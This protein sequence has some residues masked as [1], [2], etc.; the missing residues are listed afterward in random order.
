M[1][2]FTAGTTFVDGVANDVTAAKLGALITNATPTS[3]LI[4]DRTAETVVATNDTFLIGDASD[5]NTL[6]RMTVANVMKAEHTG[7]INTTAGTI[8]ELTCSSAR[9]TSGTVAFLNS[10]TATIPTLT[11]ITKITSG[12]G[13]AAAPAISPT[14]DANTGIFFPVADTIAF[15]EGGTEAMRIDASG[16]V[17]IGSSSPARLLTV[18][19]ATNPE[20]ALYT[21]GAERVKLSTGGSAAS[22]L[23]IDI[24]GTERFR[25][26]S[27]GNVGI[28]SSTPARSLTI[29]NATNP[30]IGF[31]TSGTERVKLS[32]GGSAAS[33][34]A[35]DIGG[36]ELARITSDGIS[37][38]T[39]TPT[40]LFSQSKVIDIVGSTS[41]A[42]R[43]ERTNSTNPTYGYVG[44]TNGAVQL[45][46]Q[47]NTPIVFSTYSTERARIDSDG[48]FGIGVA[49]PQTTLHIKNNGVVRINNPNGTRNLELFNDS[50]FAE[51]K[52]SVDPI[53]INTT[54]DVRILTGATPTE[55]LRVGTTGNVSIGTAT[56][57]SK[58][59]VHGD[60]TMSN[61]TTAVTAST[62]TITPPATVAGYLTVSINGTSRKIPY[63]AT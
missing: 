22:Q 42:V 43:F 23:A 32:T 6:K 61:A 3:G 9:I 53:R 38:G 52:S 49:S 7:T 12:T 35:I 31:Y 5:S 37:V 16:R 4:Q 1:A 46:S 17:G 34:L 15:A 2:S 26:S 40:I 59:H 27:V 50:S 24:E 20:I 30:D 11:S 13:T 25:I 28:G 44:A 48:N 21:S 36:S 8:E 39:T 55:R 19:N 63:Y 54:D 41:G 14:G 62:S 58:L 33:Q 45:N 47:S 18:D 51:I 10:T 60:L 29:D 57:L 56:A